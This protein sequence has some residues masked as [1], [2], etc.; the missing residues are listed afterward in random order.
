MLLTVAG[1]VAI[2]RGQ[3]WGAGDALPDTVAHVAGRSWPEPVDHEL[4]AVPHGDV[5]LP[6]A[7]LPVLV[8]ARR[9]GHDPL[10]HAG[11]GPCNDKQVRS[12]SRSR[13]SG[14]RRLE[15]VVWLSDC[16][17]C[18]WKCSQKLL[19]LSATVPGQSVYSVYSWRLLLFVSF[20]WEY[21]TGQIINQSVP[22]NSL[23]EPLAE[24][25]KFTSEWLEL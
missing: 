21:V 5:Q 7:A 3:A 14:P 17:K 4:A 15:L 23:H 8:D 12:E 18:L 22:T 10:G 19:T 16:M 1:C 2:G 9:A 11:D 24:V 13:V 6:H 20:Y 25:L